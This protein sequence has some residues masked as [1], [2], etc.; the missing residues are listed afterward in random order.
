VFLLAFVLRPVA[1]AVGSD[2]VPGP[3]GGS[4]RATGRP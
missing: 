3:P 2:P 4:V 1:R